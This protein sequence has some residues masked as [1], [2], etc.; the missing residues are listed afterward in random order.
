LRNQ[1]QQQIRR[2]FS[3]R[4]SAIVGPCST[5]TYLPKKDLILREKQTIVP[6]SSYKHPRTSFKRNNTEGLYIINTHNKKFG[7]ILSS[8]SKTKKYEQ[9]LVTRRYGSKKKPLPNTNS[10][11]LLAHRMQAA[12]ST[13]LMHSLDRNFVFGDKKLP[14]NGTNVNRSHSFHISIQPPNDWWEKSLQKPN[15]K[16]IIPR[17]KECLDDEQKSISF[18]EPTPD[19]EEEQEFIIRPIDRNEIGEEPTVDYDE[20]RSTPTY[21]PEETSSTPYDLGVSSSFIAPQTSITPSSEISTQ[22]Q[23]PIP[24]TPPP[25]PNTIIE[26]TKINV[27]CR[28]IADKITPNHKLTLKDEIE[29][30]TNPTEEKQSG[31]K[32]EPL[33]NSANKVPDF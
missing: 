26:Q 11:D 4:Y 28:T 31:K 2:R 29:A 10:V 16:H 15:Y 17:V 20:P 32:T 9:S 18:D 21:E 5:R 1:Q 19:Y 27:R 12:M 30:K 14:L 6:S 23:S 33:I 22:N 13:E 7:E 3:K 8:S 24:P 25:L